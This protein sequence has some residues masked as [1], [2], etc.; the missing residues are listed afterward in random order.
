M[1]ISTILIILL[2]LV[3][4]GSFPGFSHSRSWGYRP[5]GIIGAILVILVVLVLLGKI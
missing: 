4:I 2:I 1:S 5:F 3:L